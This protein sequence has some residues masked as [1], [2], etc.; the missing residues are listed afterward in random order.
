[1]PYGSFARKTKVRPLDDLDMLVL[2][3]EQSTLVRQA[4][5]DSYTYLV[6]IT[7][8]SSPLKPYTDENGWVLSTKILN[9]LKSGV[10]KVHSYRKSEIKR[11]GVAVVLDLT[12]Y[13][14]VFDIVP[15]LPVY[16]SSGTVLYH[17]I[18]NGKGYWMRTDPR[19][20]QEIV[21]SA[22][23]RQNGHLLPLIRLIKYW[24]IRSQAA[25]RLASYHLET[26][27]VNAYRYGYPEIDSRIRWSVPNA[28]N[29]L[30]SHVMNSCP[31]P[32][33]LGPTLDANMTWETREKIRNTANDRSLYASHALSCEQLGNHQEAIKWWGYVFPNFE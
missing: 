6:G 10:Q 9:G 19:I 1:M 18:P 20:D 8:Y 28:F 7:D 22:N 11:N 21:T 30:A 13:D 15:A 27:L 25:P 26:I 5:W 24:N 14:W 33:G 2:L 31:D 32:K 12:S 17:L 16:D 29:Q 23:Q 4:S 3:R